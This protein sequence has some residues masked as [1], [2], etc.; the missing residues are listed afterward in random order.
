MKRSQRAFTLP[1]LLIVVVIISLIAS[2]GFVQYQESRK[3]ARDE[4]RKIDVEQLAAAVRLYYEQ[5]GEFPCQQGS[6]CTSHAGSA[7]GEIGDGGTID[8]L[9][10]PYLE[11]V[12]ADPLGPGDG[13]YQYFYDGNASCGGVVAVHAIT[14]EVPTN[15]NW[16]TV[17]GADNDGSPTA[18]T[19]TVIVGNSS[20]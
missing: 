15:G 10:E 5:Y 13:T 17:C 18:D 20:G 19:Y 7:N 14:M 4:R 8:G 6:N 3:Q 2:V 16:S 12:P 11:R 1:E 9:L